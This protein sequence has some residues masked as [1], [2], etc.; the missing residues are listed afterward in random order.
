[1]NKRI[2]KNEKEKLKISVVGYAL[3]FVSQYD[4]LDS[5]HKL[6]EESPYSWKRQ[7]DLVNLF[8]IVDKLTNLLDYFPIP[9]QNNVRQI[10]DA[11]LKKLFITIRNKERHLEDLVLKK[12]IIYCSNPLPNKDEIFF[13]I[14]N[15]LFDAVQSYLNYLEWEKIFNAQ[16]KKTSWIKNY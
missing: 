6:Y 13:R 15:Q 9:K 7:N 5:K 3:N 10:E 1:M 8:R 16:L 14:E 4:F 2:P 11:G 12:A